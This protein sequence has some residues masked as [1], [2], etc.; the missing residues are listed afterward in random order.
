[1]RRVAPPKYAA[2]FGLFIMLGMLAFGTHVAAFLASPPGGDGGPITFEIVRDE[3]LARVASRLADE[4]LIRNQAYFVMFGRLT[5]SER[6][7]K[8]GEYALSPTM[9]PLEM[10]HR[11]RHGL[12]VLHPL[13]IPEGYSVRQIAAVLRDAG[14]GDP[15]ELLTLAESPEF[16]RE[17]G[18]DV[19]S[20]EGYLFP[21]TYAFPRGVATADMV[22]RM[23]ERFRETYQP[24][25]AARA[26]D[27]GLTQHQV[28][29]L[30]S[31]IE[32][33]TGAGIE[34]PIISAVFH[35]RL[36]RRMPLQSDPT[37]IYP[38]KDFN[39]NLRKVDLV[40]DNP[41]NTYRRR[42]LPPGPIANPGREALEAALYPSPVDYLYFVARNDGTHHF[43]R[44]LREHN[45][46]V[47]QY[48][49][50]GQRPRTKVATTRGA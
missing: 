32:K 36:R 4:G 7:L 31:I 6:Q 41:Y 44:T 43:S 15:D 12:V 38:I 23:V 29:T 13:T 50:R 21:D 24:V 35:N 10:L 25:W 30:A 46:A 40:R 11:F 28:V 5:G 42:G 3:P 39:G 20:L 16:A 47:D 8:P 18:L 33:E 48:Q 17:L 26:A 19:P 2:L 34:R 27:L 22:R 1:M 49:R 45:R 14:L 9:R 37:V